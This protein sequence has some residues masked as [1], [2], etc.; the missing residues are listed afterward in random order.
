MMKNWPKKN[1]NGSRLV[2]ANKFFILQT[3]TIVIIVDCICWRIFGCWSKT[4]TISKVACVQCVQRFIGHN[5]YTGYTCIIYG[6][7][8]RYLFLFSCSL[9]IFHFF[10]SSN[11]NN[12]LDKVQ[13]LLISSFDLFFCLMTKCRKKV[14]QSLFI[15]IK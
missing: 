3:L 5:S 10:S 6:W 4:F 14:M 7:D 8:I 13:C 9:Q 15:S 12:I 11:E 2:R 1:V